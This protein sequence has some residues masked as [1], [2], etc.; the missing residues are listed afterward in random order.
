M[1]LHFRYFSTF[2]MHKSFPLVQLSIQVFKVDLL[3]ALTLG[4]SQ[5]LIPEIV[6]H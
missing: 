3:K 6:K 4:I 1:A 2:Q 5:W